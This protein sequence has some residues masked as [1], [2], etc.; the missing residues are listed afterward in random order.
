ENDAPTTMAGTGVVSA[1]NGSPD[2]RMGSDS[3]EFTVP[4]C[5]QPEA[6][7]IDGAPSNG[8]VVA[9]TANG[10]ML[11]VPASESWSCQSIVN[12]PPAAAAPVAGLTTTMRSD[13]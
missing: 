10:P 6:S 2:G 4:S 5:E 11:Q 7:G 3:A 1:G 12:W 8:V 9:F 13:A